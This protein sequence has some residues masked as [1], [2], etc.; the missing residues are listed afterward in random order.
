[1]AKLPKPNTE[2]GARYEAEL[3]GLARNAKYQYFTKRIT[4]GQ[5]L[6]EAGLGD[7][8]LALDNQSF[9]DATPEVRREMIELAFNTAAKIIGCEAF[10]GTPAILKHSA[11]VPASN[12]VQ[13]AAA[14]PQQEATSVTPDV[15]NEAVQEKPETVNDPDKKQPF[16]GDGFAL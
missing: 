7:F 1:M 6:F 12:K 14:Q 9:A 3:A 4:A 15:P 11:P 16:I 8:L 13:V 5:L 10:G 2:A